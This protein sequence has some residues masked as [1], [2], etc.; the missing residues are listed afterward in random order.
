MTPADQHTVNEQS[1][2]SAFSKQSLVFDDIY[3]G[4]IIIQYKRARVREHVN[5]F[6]APG[7]NILELNAGTGEDSIYFGEAGHRVHATDLAE[8][9]LAALSAKVKARQLEKKISI[10]KCSFNALHT[11]QQKGPY[12]LIFSNFAG[13]NC[14]GQLREVLVSLWPLL[15]PK[16][17]ITLV[18]L[19]PFCL[20]ET[21]LALRGQFRLAFR[22]FNSKNG[23]RAQVEGIPFTCWYYKP[24][25]VIEAL[26]QHYEVLGLEG[27]CSIVP[28]SYL[29]RLPVRYPKTY[30]FLTR[31]E[32]KWK[33]KWPWRHIGDYYIISLRKR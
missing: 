24:S 1:A 29:E 23:V 20:W 12:D 14:T 21:I 25:F 28:P 33:T 22:R 26:Q 4:N 18:L 16:G 11:L 8:G 5:R 31:L 19:P 17:Q 3:T 15:K 7:S 30:R 6:L 10:E 9:M 27:L 13:L 32:N 2:A